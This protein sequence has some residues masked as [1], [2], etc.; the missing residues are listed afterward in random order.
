MAAGDRIYYFHLSKKDLGSSLNCVNKSSNAFD[1]ILSAE[2]S[3]IHQ[4]VP[5]WLLFL[6]YR[7]PLPVPVW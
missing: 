6:F 4:C 1:F 2:V 5:T 3:D 7:V